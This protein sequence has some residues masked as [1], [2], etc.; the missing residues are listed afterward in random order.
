[1][2]AKTSSTS[3]WITSM[4]AVLPL[5][6]SAVISLC[7]SELA[8]LCAGIYV[9]D[10]C[11]ICQAAVS[12]LKYD[13]LAAVVAILHS[14]TATCHPPQPFREAGAEC[15]RNELVALD[16][17]VGA[18]V[19]GFAFVSMVGGMEARKVGSAFCYGA[20]FPAANAT[21]VLPNKICCI[22]IVELSL[23][24]IPMCLIGIAGMNMKNTFEDSVVRSDMPSC[25]VM[26][27]VSVR[28]G[29]QSYKV[30]L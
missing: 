1:M 20:N 12:V 26:H 27:H 29:T 5:L 14:R 16:L 22:F 9:A 7:S 28:Q 17:I 21:A 2:A 11:H 19:A 18:V 6:P 8:Q 25:A 15:R 23:N 13:Y 30:I 24:L 10:G 3:S 4:A